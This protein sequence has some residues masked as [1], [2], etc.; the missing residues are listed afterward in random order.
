MLEHLRGQFLPSRDV[1][2]SHGIVAAGREDAFT[3][4]QK[5]SGRDFSAVT[6]EQMQFLTGR[7]VPDSPASDGVAREQQLAI[8]RDGHGGHFRVMCRRACAAHCRS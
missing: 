6:G 1:P 3:T 5:M 7:G 2:L 8:R 4:G